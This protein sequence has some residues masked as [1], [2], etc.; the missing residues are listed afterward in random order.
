MQHSSLIATVK[1]ILPFGVAMHVML[2][3]QS[4]IRHKKSH[5]VAKE[6]LQVHLKALQASIAA[7]ERL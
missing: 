3:E 1:T 6:K 2:G 7:N 5:N 4:P